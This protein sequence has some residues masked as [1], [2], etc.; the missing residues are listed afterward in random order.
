MTS[1]APSLPAPYTRVAVLDREAHAGLRLDRSRV[2]GFAARLGAVPLAVGEFAAAAGHLPIVFTMGDEPGPL[3]VTGLSPDRNLF[4]GESGAWQVGTY[5]PAYLRRFP[6]IL[7]EQGGVRALGIEETS[8]LLSTERGEPLFKSGEP[9]ATLRE[10]LALCE[11][12]AAEVEIGS[13]LGTA[14]AERE[15]LRDERVTVALP[16]GTANVTGFRV[17]DAERFARLDEATVLDWHRRGWLGLV[18][19]HLISLARWDT[20]VRLAAQG[21]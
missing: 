17:V 19:A 18:H 15:L 5:I 6:F 12:Y 3:G 8:P 1:A 2:Y 9:S 7:I 14:L 21:G 10:I 11:V 13:A 20:L 16:G 4:V